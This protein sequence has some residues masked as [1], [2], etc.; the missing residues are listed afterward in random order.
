MGRKFN[1]TGVTG[2]VGLSLAQLAYAKPTMEQWSWLPSS[3][4]FQNGRLAAG[5][6]VS[7]DQ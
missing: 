6:Y 2:Y 5:E 1:I 4:Y 7:F 3:K